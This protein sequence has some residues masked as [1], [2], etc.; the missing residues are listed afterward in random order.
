MTEFISN[1][2][3]FSNRTM[4]HCWMD[5]HWIPYIANCALCNIEYS[6]VAKLEN[7]Q[8]DLQFIGQMAG[9]EFEMIQINPSSGGSTSELAREYFSQLKKDDVKKL[10]ELYKIDFLMFGYSPDVYFNIAK[11]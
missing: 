6:A 10:Y 2:L 4:A 9:I 5:D 8:E 7:I 1:L 3:V 11:N